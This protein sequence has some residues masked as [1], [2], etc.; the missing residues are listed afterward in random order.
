MTTIQPK[1]SVILKIAKVSK[2]LKIFFQSIKNQTIASHVELILVSCLK[3]NTMLHLDELRGV[4]NVVI[5]PIDDSL[6]EG[7]YKTA[8]FNHT[9]APYIMFLED[10]S[11]P[12]SDCF[13]K[14][15]LA[16]SNE[17]LSVVG[18]VV[19]NANPW[20][21]VSWGSYL[22]FYGQ[23]GY[24]QPGEYSKH[25]PANQSC[26]SRK[27]LLAHRETLTEKLKTESIFHW[28]LISQGHK[29][30]LT[31]LAKVYHLNPSRLVC[32]LKEY[33]LNSQI[34]ATSRFS[35]EQ[36][37]LRFIYTIGSPVMPLVRVL[38]IARI[39]RAAALPMTTF[40]RALP[41]LFLCLC[42]GAVGEMAGY[43]IGSRNAEE[44]LNK[45]MK[46]PDFLVQHNDLEAISIE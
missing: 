14:I 2:S 34:F 12:S 22:V 6:H 24:E 44:H 30:K 25:L 8:G 36:F 10:H 42:S 43:S 5:V 46:N 21:C 16:H 1:I 11:F 32:L 39:S 38:R 41:F 35:R 20:S 15:L 26:Y 9:S 37:F 18:P 7:E 23:W 13:E 27:I 3:D 4:C 40:A 33:F 45:L 29:L 31:E 17:D 28:E 19:L